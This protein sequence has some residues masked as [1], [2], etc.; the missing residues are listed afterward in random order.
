MIKNYFSKIFLAISISRNIHTFLSLLINSKK[1]SNKLKNK[2]LDPN[3]E[4][5]RKYNVKM[6]GRKFDLLIRTYK[7]DISIFNE[8]FWKKT[9]SIP[10]NYLK[11][12]H[13]IIDL[14][15][16]VGFTSVFYSLQYPDSKVY[17]VEASKKNFNILKE[18]VKTFENITAINKVIY[19]SDGQILFDDSGVS[20]NTKISSKGDLMESISMNTLMNTYNIEKIDLIKIDIEGAEKELLKSNNSWLEI[21]DNIII[22]LHLPYD[23]DELKSDLGNFDFKIITPNKENGLKNI[24][25]TKQQIGVS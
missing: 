15:A 11:N 25:A 3:D 13:T 10:S 5:S 18:N 4:S 20:Y 8:I 17:S 16:H 1:Y 23:I 6:S 21:T 7:G 22:E 12:P 14:G 19:P 24:F 9:Y 2:I